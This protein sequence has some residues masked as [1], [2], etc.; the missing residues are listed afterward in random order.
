MANL[1][2]QGSKNVAAQGDG[3]TVTTVG[4]DNVS[5]DGDKFAPILYLMQNL[6]EQVQRLE[7]ELRELSH[8]AL[9]MEHSLES[10][11]RWN[12]WLA[13]GVAANTLGLF[14]IIIQVVIFLFATASRP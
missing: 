4:R 14:I 1:S 5:I 3:N 10:A 6:Q 13:A 12:M 2:A 11:T 8:R 7:K 9:S